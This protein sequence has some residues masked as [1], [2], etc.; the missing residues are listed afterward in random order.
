MLTSAL[1]TSIQ[2]RAAVPNAQVTFSS[3]DFY[4][5]MDEEIESKL[6]PLVLSTLEEYYVADF[7]YNITN[8]VG[9]YA[10]PTRAIAGKLRDVQVISS[11][12]PDSITPLERL[13]ITDLFSSTSSSYRVLIKKSGFYLK[14][15]N[16][17][18]YPTPTTTQNIINLEHYRRPNTCVDPSTCAV[19]TAINLVANTIT[20]SSLPSNITTATPVDLVKVNSGFGCTAIDQVITNIAGN[21]LT[22]SAPLLSSV[23]VGDY[24][25]QATQTCVVQVPQELLPLLSQY[26]VVRVL[27]AQGDLQAYQ[28]AIT[29]LGSIEKNALMMITPRVDGKPKRVT[30]TRGVSRFV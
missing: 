23:S 2:R 24:V 30:N 9:S 17:V 29:E 28:Q 5:L 26:V 21:I 25:C 19:I 16:V 10:I 14:A 18:M 12:D 20:V 22:F 6:V 1:I 27:S 4:A 13:D 8:G 7:P 15:D 3:A 11:T